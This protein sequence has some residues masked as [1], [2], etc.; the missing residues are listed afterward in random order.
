[1]NRIA[2]ALF[3]A[4]L[5]LLVALSVK[6]YA[7]PAPAGGGEAAPARAARSVTEAVRPTNAPGPVAAPPQVQPP[8][9]AP[10]PVTAARILDARRQG[11]AQALQKRRDRMELERHLSGD[12][13]PRVETIV[14]TADNRFS[15]LIGD[16]L[17]SEGG[18]VQGYRVR[19]ITADSVEFEKNGKT[20]VQ[21]VD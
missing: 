20:W 12:P 16:A 19:K 15:A 3:A 21:T 9:F 7:L 1:M 10:V 18:T 17:V 8:L 11:E 5:G 13:T 2:W 14:A 4:M 6:K